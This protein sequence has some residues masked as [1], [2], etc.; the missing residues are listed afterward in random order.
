[1]SWMSEKHK[2]LRACNRSY[3]SKIV[4]SEHR[5]NCQREMNTECC[6]FRDLIHAFHLQYR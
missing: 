5:T 1:M 6:V 2:I 3:L 4:K